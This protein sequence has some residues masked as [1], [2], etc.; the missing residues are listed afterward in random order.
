MQTNWTRFD[1]L[2]FR[3]DVLRSDPARLAHLQPEPSI[4][5]SAREMTREWRTVQDTEPYR[6]PERRRL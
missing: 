6:G 5:W 3:R 4:D 2:N 1:E